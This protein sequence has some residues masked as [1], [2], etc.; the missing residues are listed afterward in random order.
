MKIN[1]RHI[2]IFIA[3]I[4]VGYTIWRKRILFDNARYA[5][6]LTGKISWT[7]ASGRKLEFS[8]MVNG[9]R[10]IEEENYINE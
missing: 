10:Y 1:G 2:F 5:I 6:G 9:K 8:Y 7:V 4:L 3:L